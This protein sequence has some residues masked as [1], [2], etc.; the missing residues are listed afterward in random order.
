MLAQQQHKLVVAVVHLQLGLHRTR[1]EATL[2]VGDLPQLH[3]EASGGVAE[4]GAWFIAVEALQGTIKVCES[5]H[6][7]ENSNRRR[8]ESEIHFSQWFSCGCGQLLVRHALQEGLR[9]VC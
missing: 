4:T 5:L 7:A 6:Q 3:R 1:F 9:H 8:G 2:V